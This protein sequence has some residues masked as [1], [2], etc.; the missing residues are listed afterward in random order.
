[1]ENAS[2]DRPGRSPAHGAER[3]QEAAR[4]PLRPQQG[5]PV[6]D[7]CLRDESG[8]PESR[9]GS[10]VKVGS[11]RRSGPAGGTGTV[12]SKNRARVADSGH[13]RRP[14]HGVRGHG[15]P[16]NK[17]PTTTESAAVPRHAQRPR[18]PHPIC[19]SPSRSHAHRLC[20]G[21]DPQL[22]ASALLPHGG[23]TASLAFSFFLSFSNLGME[24][25]ETQAVASTPAWQ[26]GSR[27]WAHSPGAQDME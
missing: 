21:R 1:M 6:R 9:R 18:A 15:R 27:G 19:Q 16:N 23:D 26:G 4:R 8:S 7:T 22:Q 17:G 25:K 11:R 5:L 13:A 2:L 3:D 14:A 12:P 10:Q 24:P 20:W